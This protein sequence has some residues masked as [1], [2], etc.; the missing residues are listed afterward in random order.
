VWSCASPLHPRPASVEFPRHAQ[1]KI[2]CR[3][4][5]ALLPIC[6]IDDDAPARGARGAQFQFVAT[7]M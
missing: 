2:A 1:R 4:T 7:A 5:S 3:T 6:R